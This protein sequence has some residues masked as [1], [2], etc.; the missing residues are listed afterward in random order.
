M[1]GALK[2]CK[3]HVFQWERFAALLWASWW[4]VTAW[5]HKNNT[6]FLKELS[7]FFQNLCELS[8]LYFPGFSSMK[9]FSTSTSSF[10]Q[11]HAHLEGGLQL[12]ML[13][14]AVGLYSLSWLN[15]WLPVKQSFQHW[16]CLHSRR[17]SSE[18]KNRKREKWSKVKHGKLLAILLC[19]VY[20]GRDRCWITSVWLSTVGI[21]TEGVFWVMLLEILFLNRQTTLE[22]D[23]RT[24]TESK[25]V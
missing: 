18:K 4:V 17:N 9:M 1:G 6:P 25:I 21:V 12:G 22:N 8:S 20:R 5:H 19:S 2:R 23:S 16:I 3:G 14:L 24:L 13:L 7:T 15:K 11:S 10:G